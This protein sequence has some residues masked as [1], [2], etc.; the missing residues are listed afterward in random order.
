MSESLITQLMQSMP[1]SWGLD[2]SPESVVV[3]YVRELERRVVALGGDLEHDGSVSDA[4]A[5]F[6]ELAVKHAT[7]EAVDDWNAMVDAWAVYVT[8]KEAER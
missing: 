3:S 4:R 8:T 7:T 5:R 1:A 6:N 2:E